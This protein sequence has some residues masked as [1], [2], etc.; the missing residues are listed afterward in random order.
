MLKALKVLVFENT[1]GHPGATGI[2]EFIHYQQHSLYH[3]SSVL[4]LHLLR[5]INCGSGLLD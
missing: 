4:T 2:T 1:N 5:A 3:L